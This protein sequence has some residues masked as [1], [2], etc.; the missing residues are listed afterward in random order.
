MALEV[1]LPAALGSLPIDSIARIVLGRP[2]LQVFRVAAA[3]I[4]AGVEHL[5]SF[6]DR[7]VR[8]FPGQAVDHW[9]A[10]G[11]KHAP[12]AEGAKLARPDMTARLGIDFDIGLQSLCGGPA[13]LPA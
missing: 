8:Q 2:E 4:V 12:I 9:V 13:H 10:S 5:H 11:H 7:P 6:G 3:A 1:L